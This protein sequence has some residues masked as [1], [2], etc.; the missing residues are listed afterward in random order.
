MMV[1]I[2]SR[3]LSHWKPEHNS[4]G[5]DWDII[6]SPEEVEEYIGKS[7]NRFAYSWKHGDI[8]FHNENYFDNWFVKKHYNSNSV[9]DVG[10]VSVLVCSLRGLAAI[11]RSHLWR[12]KDFA[13]HMIQYQL[14]DRNF[15]V[16]DLGFIEERKKLIE[17]AF[18]QPT[19]PRNVSNEDFFKDN[20]QR[21]FVHDDIHPIVSY[22]GVPLY[23]ALKYDSSMAECELNLWNSISALD[24]HRAVLEETYVIALERWIIPARIEGRN[25]PT[26]MALFKALE[27]CCTTL[28]EGFFRE[29]AIDHWGE[30][31]KLFDTTKVDKFFESQ[32]W[33]NRS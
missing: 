10:N 22:Y 28:G 16:F 7:I 33:K 5:K 20:V 19:A 18:P 25:Y 11:K 23:E 4:K 26:R 6:A 21:V 32:L 9:L 2:G 1:L 15:D 30:I 29:H 8:E 27:K 13:K 24:R 17:E 3:A 14:M 31:V 12:R